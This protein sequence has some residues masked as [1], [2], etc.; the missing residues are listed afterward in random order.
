MQLFFL[1][2][3]KGQTSSSQEIVNSPRPS[4]W[5]RPCSWV[6]SGLDQLIYPDDADSDQTLA[7]DWSIQITWPQSWPLIGRGWRMQI[8]TGGQTPASTAQSSLHG[9]VS[10]LKVGSWDTEALDQAW[11]SLREARL[12]PLHIWHSLYP[13]SASRFRTPAASSCDLVLQCTVQELTS[14]SSMAMCCAQE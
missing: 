11:A 14:S 5:P 12:R 13:A 3:G 1:R 4:L 2:K 7:S 9:P 10:S 8:V 6:P